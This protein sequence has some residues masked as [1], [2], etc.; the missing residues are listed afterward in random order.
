MACSGND[1]PTAKAHSCAH[2][3]H[4]LSAL[5]VLLFMK[6]PKLYAILDAETCARRGFGLLTVAKAWRDAGISLLQYRDKPGSDFEILRN[7]AAINE[8]FAGTDVTLILNDRVHLF[9]R[10]GFRGVH[11]GQSD[12]SISAVRIAVGNEAIVGISTHNPQQLRYAGAEPVS[13]AAIGPVHSTRTK[14]DAEPVVG[15]E[16]VRTARALTT[17]PL[18]AIGGITREN[19]PDV[20]ATGAD[21]VAVIGALLPPAGASLSA[22]DDTA[23]DFLRAIA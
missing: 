16:G 1:H 23:R 8:L 9:S 14:L 6:L 21:C 20:L 22:V 4:V 11:V 15:L 12:Q 18:V 17:L 5:R 3:V 7:A 2:R 10:T 13:Y 19:A